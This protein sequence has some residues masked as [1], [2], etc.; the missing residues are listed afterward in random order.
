MAMT[1][2]PI[3]EALVIGAAELENTGRGIRPHRL[4]FWATKHYSDPQLM[5]VEAQPS[6]VRLVFRSQAARIELLS[7]A[8]RVSYA[9]A[10]RPR[11]RFD[12]IV[13]G[14][15]RATDLLTEGDSNYTDLLAGTSELRPGGPHLTVFSDLGEGE[16]DIEIWLPHNESLELI[17]LT[18]DAP[19]SPVEQKELLW[20]HHG[21][22][23]SHGL[24]AAGPTD[25]WPAIA[26]RVDG[27]QL[28]NLGLA[29]S[30]LLDP[31]TARVIR[32]APADIISLKI[33]INIVNL[34]S[35]RLRTFE[36][37]L[38][39]FLD[40][41][42]DGHPTV[43]IVLVSPIFCGI[44]ENTPGP[45]SV[46][47]TTLGTGHIRFIATGEEG[48]TSFGR[49]TLQVI[50]QAIEAVVAAR[51]DAELHYVNGLE[52]YGPEDA[53]LLPLPDALHPD[54]VAHKLIG[55]RFARH[56]SRMHTPGRSVG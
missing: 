2:T 54:T 47:A 48:D 31:F 39:G 41:I 8:L 13:D 25:I 24:N 30:A 20:V 29:G 38:H 32:D 42:R 40:T 45:E 51:A 1:T 15:L 35:M 36:P 46:D 14:T 27:L 37:A 19:I 56:L 21:S 10:D 5:A 3:S 9:G 52:L 33:G 17:S 18:T 43:P 53:E 26:A 23:I 22:S 7:H 16:K 6:G 55:E 49:L 12:L 50:R 28:R 44:H 4:P 11:G 34:D